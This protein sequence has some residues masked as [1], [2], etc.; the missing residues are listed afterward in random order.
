[1]AINLDLPALTEKLDELKAAAKQQRKLVTEW[2]KANGINKKCP[3]EYK[4]SRTTKEGT[5]LDLVV[6][7]LSETIAHLESG[8]FEVKVIPKK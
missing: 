3:F 6:Q 2:H 8:D 7:V 5:T 1:M 4:R